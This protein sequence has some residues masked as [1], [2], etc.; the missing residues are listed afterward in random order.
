MK[1]AAILMAGILLLTAGCSTAK[2]QKSVN[3]DPKIVSQN[4][5]PTKRS[6][7][8][9]TL[10]S[11]HADPPFIV[12]NAN[13]PNNVSIYLQGLKH[14]SPY[15]RWYAANKVISYYEMPR[16]EEVI[17]Q[18]K[19]M[20]D[21]DPNEEVKKAAKFSL[22]VL[23][24]EFNGSEFIK[25]PN[26]KYIAFHRFYDGIS[27]DGAVFM[28]DKT[29]RKLNIVAK[30]NS[31]INLNWSPDST[32]LCITY[33]VKEWS[34]TGFIKMSD[35]NFSTPATAIAK[36]PALIEYL[37]NNKE[38]YSI[39]S[40]K[41]DR[42]N[43]YTNLLEWSPDSKKLLLYYSFTDDDKKIQRGAAVYD[44]TGDKYEKIIPYEQ[45]GENA[46]IEK[47]KGFKWN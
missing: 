13:E 6:L 42:L 34:E 16:K 1:R 41:L 43:S 47:P 9:D 21:S 22:S 8:W 12:D 28:Y 29:A 45:S 27:N 23:R 26:E 2:D 18:L 36:R 14:G 38:K 25:S 7:F 20:Q 35:V 10:A 5:A 30:T 46:S 11:K 24:R 33:G 17:E 19:T 4:S 37:D 39:K 15:V 44:T 31:I 32:K 40:Q 3:V